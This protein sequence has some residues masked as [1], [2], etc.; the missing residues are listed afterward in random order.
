MAFEDAPIKNNTNDPANQTDYAMEEILKKTLGEDPID[1]F[2]ETST[3]DDFT[4]ESSDD[5]GHQDDSEQETGHEE[6]A[7]DTSEE[8]SQQHEESDQED[9]AGKDDD[10]EVQGLEFIKE[11]T[12]ELLGEEHKFE[13]PEDY[14]QAVEKVVSKYKETEEQLNSEYETN[15]KLINA[16][17]NNPEFKE[18]AKGMVNGKSFNE[19]LFSV[20]NPDQMIPDKQKEPEKYAEY[21]AGKKE[22]ERAEADRKQRLDENLK[23]TKS[24]IDSFKENQSLE[25]SEAKGIIKKADEI[26]NNVMQGLLTNDMLSL[27]HKGL[28]YDKAV[29]AARE[30]AK[31]EGAKQGR[32]ETRK[33]RQKDRQGDGL[34]QPP[35]GSGG[36]APKGKGG[37]DDDIASMLKDMG[38]G[39]WT[40]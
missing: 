17:E 6:S 27:I 32:S 37:P 40:N 22:R 8:D 21:L 19:A 25:E 1:E 18:V 39:G 2:G 31:Q 24:E 15:Q 28:N 26:A 11:A 34:P 5:T 35:A 13:K 23:K 14:Q 3:T 9:D 20:V 33:R 29:E 7:E 12:S 38:Q 36:A 10:D 30:E 16:F 4:D